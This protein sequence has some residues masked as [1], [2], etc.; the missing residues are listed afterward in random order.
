M[1]NSS[2][3]GF[4]AGSKRRGCDTGGGLNLTPMI[5]TFIVILIFLVKSYSTSPSYITPTQGIELSE[6]V[7]SEGA[8]NKPSLIVGKDGLFFDNK[9][10]YPFK[11]G[12]TPKSFHTKNTI[13]E[14]QVLF[15]RIKGEDKDFTGTLIL[16]AD[17]SITY[18]ILKPILRTAGASGFNDIKIAGIVHD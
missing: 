7:S 14:L 11:D 3:R 17:K 13:K 18:K 15:N 4:S 2:F 8:P 5:D 16:Q 10:V 9:L 1:K 6:T 12:K